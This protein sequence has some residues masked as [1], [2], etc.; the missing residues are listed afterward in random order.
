MLRDIFLSHLCFKIEN[1]IQI[2]FPSRWTLLL[3]GNLCTLLSKKHL[4]FFVQNS[5]KI[6]NDNDNVFLG[7]GRHRETTTDCLSVRGSRSTVLRT[8]TK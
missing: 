4:F 2:P 1:D 5:T 7:R 6:K 3:S 8:T